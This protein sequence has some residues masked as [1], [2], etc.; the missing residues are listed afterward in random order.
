M[1]AS[2]F[3]K[4][5]CTVLQVIFLIVAFVSTFSINHIVITHYIT[6]EIVVMSFI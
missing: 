6:Y 2:I 4:T 1:A 5:C 3:L